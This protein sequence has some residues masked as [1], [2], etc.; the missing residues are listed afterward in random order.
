MSCCHQRLNNPIQSSSVH[1]AHSAIEDNQNQLVFML[2]H[3]PLSITYL[4]LCSTATASM[5]LSSRTVGT[6]G[7]SSRVPARR[8]RVSSG[9]SPK[10]SSH[11]YRLASKSLQE[12]WYYLMFSTKC[13]IGYKFD[14]KCINSADMN[15]RRVSL[16]EWTGLHQQSN[17]SGKANWG[18]QFHPTFHT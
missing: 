7:Y 14:L 6:Y 17:T 1:P 8:S 12:R 5:P 16:S 11:R 9:S 3:F 15:A 2:K 4:R 18:K 13:M 10:A